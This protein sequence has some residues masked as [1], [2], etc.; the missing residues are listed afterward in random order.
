[1][2][3]HFQQVLETI[4]VANQDQ[5]IDAL[6]ILTPAEHRPPYSGLG[7]RPRS[8]FHATGLSTNYS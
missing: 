8:K 7:M 4:Y 5:R 6:P 1:M 3:R 2:L